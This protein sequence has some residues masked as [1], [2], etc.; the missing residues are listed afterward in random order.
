MKESVEHE[1]QEGKL[2][3]VSME[4]KRYWKQITILVV[5]LQNNLK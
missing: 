1:V 4:P 2:Q 5:I 3:S